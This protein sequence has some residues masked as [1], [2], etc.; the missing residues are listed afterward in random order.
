MDSKENKTFRKCNKNMENHLRQMNSILFL[1]DGSKITNI[2]M[3][4][5]P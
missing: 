5:G 4:L 2:Q 3:I 1:D